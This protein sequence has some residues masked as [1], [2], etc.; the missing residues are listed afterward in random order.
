MPKSRIIQASAEFFNEGIVN[1][2]S[3]SLSTG[4]FDFAQHR[5]LRLRSAH[6]A[7]TSLST[8]FEAEKTEHACSMKAIGHRSRKIV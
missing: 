7:S 8:C 5:L 1:Y 3:T 2:A 6:V 4:C